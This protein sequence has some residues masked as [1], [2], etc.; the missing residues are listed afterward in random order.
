[1]DSQG[2]GTVKKQNLNTVTNFPFGKG[3]PIGISSL[4][5]AQQVHS[6][7]C[8]LTGMEEC[9]GV[10]VLILIVLASWRVLVATSIEFVRN[11]QLQASDASDSHLFCSAH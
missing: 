11:R 10:S 3:A 1:M 4:A 9:S 2:V 8:N 6:Q 5:S 7:S